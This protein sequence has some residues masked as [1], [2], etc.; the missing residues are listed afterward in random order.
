MNWWIEIL[1]S[2]LLEKLGELTIKIPKGDLGI[3]TMDSLFTFGFKD[4]AKYLVNGQ[5]K[6]TEKS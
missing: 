2:T 1:I 4:I 6:A 3:G 5:L